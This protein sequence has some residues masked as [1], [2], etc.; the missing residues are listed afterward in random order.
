MADRTLETLRRESLWFE[1]VGQGVHPA[2]ARRARDR[3]SC[4]EMFGEDPACKNEDDHA[5]SHD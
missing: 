2:A 3:Y 5:T 1:P 4:F